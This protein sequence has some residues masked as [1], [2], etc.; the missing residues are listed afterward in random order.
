MKLV[1]STGDF[2]GYVGSIEEE[3]RSFKDSK[4]KYINLEQVDKSFEEDGEQW[5]RKVDA[6]G[7]AAAYAGISFFGFPFS[8][9][10]CLFQNG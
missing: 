4:F 3:I 7:E 10:Q 8:L 9:R 6:W 5:R 2:T 1:T